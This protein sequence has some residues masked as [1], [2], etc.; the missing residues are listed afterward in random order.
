VEEIGLW[1]SSAGNDL[2]RK[3]SITISKHTKHIRGE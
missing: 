1:K 2:V 3:A